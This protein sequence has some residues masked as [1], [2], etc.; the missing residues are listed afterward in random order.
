MG[1]SLNIFSWLLARP[2]RAPRKIF[3]SKRG[4]QP[5]KFGNRCSRPADPNL[6]R[7]AYHFVNVFRL[8]DHHKTFPAKIV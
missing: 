1:S 5:E 2:S 4:P 6:F 3:N 7:L 8:E